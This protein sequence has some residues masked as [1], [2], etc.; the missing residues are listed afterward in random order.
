MAMSDV[1]KP[2]Y[3]QGSA[4]WFF[5]EFWVM[6]FFGS[7]FVLMMSIPL[8]MTGTLTLPGIVIFF[9]FILALVLALILPVLLP[10]FLLA[11]A[12]VVFGIQPGALQVGASIA[13][14]FLTFTVLGMVWLPSRRSRRS[15]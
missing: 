13:V 5:S 8:V 14:C 2:H 7:L 6:I 3:P 9:S 15:R 12:V 10:V 4:G 1:D 11:M